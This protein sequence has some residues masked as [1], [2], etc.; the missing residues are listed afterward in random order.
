MKQTFQRLATFVGSLVLVYLIVVVAILGYR[1]YQERI[2]GRVVLEV[3]LDTQMVEYVPDDPV[4]RAML[5]DRVV[6]RDVV[7]ALD[8]ASNDDRVV[9]LVAWIEAFPLSMAQAQEVRDAI[10]RFR[11]KKKFAIAYSETFG[12]FG[13]A[14]QAYYLATACD[15]IWLQPS[16]DLG[17]TGY[18]AEPMFLAGAF[19]KLGAR[20][21]G[22]QRYEY[23]NALNTYTEKKFTPAHRESL[24]KVVETWFNQLVR[25][26]AQGRRLSEPDVRSLI[27]RGP[28]LGSEAVAAKLVDGV[29]YRD[30]VLAKVKQRAG[31]S[32]PFLFLDKYLERA[33]RPHQE[34][35]TIALIYGV[36]EVQRGENSYDPI[37]G[38][39][40]M[41][42][43]TVA[44]AFRAAVAD[45]DV[46]AILFRVD[47]PGG[48]Y[49]ASDT[50]WREVVRARQAGKPVIVSMGFL[51]GSGGYFVAMPADKIVAQPG[52][53]TASIGVLAGKLLTSGF[54]EKTGISWD[55]LHF[56]Q[57]ATMWTGTH[58]Y[59]PTEW[60][61]F[62]AALDRI[63]D[64]FTSKVADGRKMP[65]DEV[66]KIARGRIWSGE[67][68]KA[69]GLVDELGGFPKA[70]ELA[71]KAANIPE[72][73]EVKLKLFPERKPFLQRLLEKQ[74]D[75]SERTAVQ[76]LEALQPV[77]RQ[78]RA[79]TG[80][81]QGVLA[82][83]DSATQP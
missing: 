25:G 11:A 20:F 64:D 83:P 8:R 60:A 63:Y 66:L 38:D 37:F 47:S 27:D 52:T 81:N 36:G 21:H 82:M 4:A 77:L 12:E 72:S 46:K 74:P 22:D 41:G 42:S 34:G 76:V 31:E 65:K 6:V 39:I 80:A 58:D 32:T 48:S 15:E 43:D 49:V 5:R 24:G 2:P 61:R 16:G 57:N 30:E 54:W 71:K 79:L 9:G 53:V 1:K 17:L 62:Q 33:G 28:F 70:L 35:K 18:M 68:A 26:I 50:I 10:E 56:G 19:E 73:E 13:P 3:H 44:A 40:R 7:D 23:K 67:D 51:A 69:L 55:E 45:K 78:L 75:S 59:S 14:N 29:A